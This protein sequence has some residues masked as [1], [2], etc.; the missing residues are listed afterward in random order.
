MNYILKYIFETVGFRAG[1]I[2]KMYFSIKFFE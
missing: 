2:R 1:V